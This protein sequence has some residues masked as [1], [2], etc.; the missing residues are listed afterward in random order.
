MSKQNE[1][2]DVTDTAIWIAAYRAEETAREDALF[3]DP[4]ATLLIGEQGLSIATRTQG[5]RYTAWSVVIRTLII[6]KFILDLIAAGI[7]TVVNLGAGLDTRPYRLELPLNIK[8][9]EVD[10]NKIIDHKNDKLNNEIPKCR[11]ERIGL[12][13]SIEEE[14]NKLLEKISKEN[15]RVLILSEGVVPYLTNEEVKSL[16]DSLVQ[17]KKFEYWITE[18]YSPEILDFLRTP[19]RLKQMINSPFKFY[20]ENWFHFFKNS[21][22]IEKETK[23]FGIEADKYGRTPPTPGWLKTDLTNTEKQNSIKYYLGYT[24]YQNLIMENQLR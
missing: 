19:K 18:Y 7:D 3:K 16:A 10:F 17:Y 20:P 21:G 2:H 8:W 23:Y 13:L 22:W 12:D 9:I 1:I 4:Y 5:S 11:L 24:I 15:N 6:D 14:R